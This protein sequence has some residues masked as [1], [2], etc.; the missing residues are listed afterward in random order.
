MGSTGAKSPFG[1]TCFFGW[2]FAGI[3]E[4]I[5]MPSGSSLGNGSKVLLVVAVYL[6]NL[7][8]K[9]LELRAPPKWSFFWGVEGL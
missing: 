1:K 9:Y 6:L 3:A 7:I 8:M 5:T 2:C 4:V